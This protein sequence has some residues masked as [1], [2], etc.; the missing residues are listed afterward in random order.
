MLSHRQQI[1]A[2]T[3]SK[4]LITIFASNKRVSQTHTDES[5]NL[6]VV[7]KVRF[8]DQ[9][10]EEPVPQE[11][12]SDSTSSNQQ[13]QED[14]STS[15]SNLKCHSHGPKFLA[16]DRETQNQIRKIHQNLGHPDN[17]VL[18]LALKRYGWNDN[19]VS[20]CADFVCPACFEKKQPKVSRPGH[21]HEPRDFNDLVSFDGAEWTDPAG[22]TYSFFHFI[23]SATNFH[24]AISYQQRTTESLIH[25]F[26]TAWIRWAGPPKKLMF[27][28]ATEANSE[29]FSRYLQQQAIQCYVIPAEAHWQLGRAERHGA[30]LKHMIDLYHGDNPIKN[31]E[32]FEQCLV[33]LCNAKNSMSRHAGYSPELWV[34]GKMKPLP[35]NNI[36]APVDSASF[37]GLD[38]T[39]T[40]GEKFHAQLA[41]RETARLAFVRA[42]H[43]ASLRKAL[44]ARSRPDRTSFSIGDL[45]MYWREGKG[46]D[47]GR[48]RGP[49]KVLMIESQNLVWLSH[50]TRLYRCAPEHVRA[51]S[52][53]ETKSLTPDD[54]QMFSLPNRSGTGVFQ[55]RE[56]SRQSSPP[57]DIT[58]NIQQGN[59]DN[60]ETIIVQ[61]NPPSSP[62]GNAMTRQPT[63]S[64]GQPD[65][66]PSSNEI[67]NIP[68]SSGGP[69]DFN[70]PVEV[71]VPNENEDEDCLFNQNDHDYWEFRDQCIIRHHRVPRIHMFFPNDIWEVPFEVAELDDNRHTKGQ[72]LSGST[73][74]RKETW[75]NDVAAHQPTP[76]PW[77]GTTTFFLQRNPSTSINPHHVSE[78]YNIQHNPPTVNQYE[79]ILTM[80]E[81]QKC[82]GR[83]YEGQEAFL[84]SAAKR[85]KVEV[86]LR[87]LSPDELELFKKAK[88]KE[89]DSW[90]STDTV[91]RILRNQVPEGQLLRSR[92]VLTWKTLD[93]VEQKETG[94]SRKPKAR[95]VILGFEDPMIDSLPRDSPTLGKDSRMLALQ[96]IASHRW[97]VRSFDIRTA[98]LR[99]SRQDTRILGVEP[100]QELRL[101]MNLR[102]D[103]V[104]ELLKGAYGLVNAPLLWYC[105][106]KNALLGLGF[107]I[108][109][110]D[111]CLF[112]LPKKSISSP[113]EPKIHGVLGV[114][115]DD[116]LGGGDQVFNHA[117]K[118][119]EKRFPFGSQRQGSFTFTGINLVQDHNGDINLNQKEY[120]NDIPPINV[121]RE[122]RQ[123]LDSQ[124]THQD[125]QD[126]RGLIGSL[127]YAASNT[128]PDLS[129]RLSLLQARIT[130]ARVADL[131]HGNRLLMDAK[132]NS[133]T[134][135]RI[136]ALEP[137]KVRFLSFS[138]AAFATREKAHSQK[139]CLIMATTDEVNE[140][141]SAPVSP[142]LWF[143]KKI[144]RVVSS[145]LASETFAL[146]GAL[147]LLSWTRIHWA[148]ILDPSIPWKTP[149]TTLKKLPSAFSVV[150]CGRVC[151]IYSKR[152]LYL[153]AQNTVPHWKLWS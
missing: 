111:P 143:S 83:S 106:L 35:G 126:L 56:L 133:D 114:H 64:V 125:L 137:S 142:L 32:D 105:E 100:P 134:S 104:C 117:I 21:L 25:S 118:M 26:N 81:M 44:H 69:I 59:R 36:S 49:A 108:S 67:S 88:S 70:G 136:Q 73:F 72:F 46:V 10:R 63:P 151:M 1:R 102:D 29:E 39:S 55:F 98:F 148:W 121:A 61:D 90:L 28:S 53:D 54:R 37:A 20:G 124:V 31:H 122:R 13:T 9:M 141:R 18:Q 85:Q 89:I 113:E 6:P 57:T 109:P 7:K 24:T 138:D 30:I 66:E 153:S 149:E 119:L 86:K 130:C 79:I 147:D 99:G 12:N 11:D 91:R 42:D 76:E 3:P 146:S 51:L 82:L 92:W 4:I 112:V 97:G 16:L 110:M 127:Q 38:E 8:A 43:S 48:W 17:R 47:E 139:G 107:T 15:Q 2:G 135:I 93:A 95:L 116:G 65:A 5:E 103:E 132:R 14:I 41:R 145:T 33:H 101:K 128:R 115:V 131:L 77:T 71:P 50:M 34:L 74:E 144:N 40:E 78:T 60:A 27:D 123:Q 52:E 80:D 84:A 23:D 152:P 94:M 22:K 140:A 62:A 75:R 120:I 45:V 58:P 129:C 68:V 96:C 150:D 87:D 19:D